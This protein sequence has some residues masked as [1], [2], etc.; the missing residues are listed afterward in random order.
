MIG[1]ATVRATDNEKECDGVAA[2]ALMH[3]GLPEA[4]LRGKEKEFVTEERR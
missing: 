1:G 3:A 4:L 2:V